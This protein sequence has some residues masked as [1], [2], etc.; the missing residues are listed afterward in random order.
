MNQ[1]RMPSPAILIAVLAL[2]AALAGTAVAGPDAST[3]AVSKK[4][5]KKIATKQINKLAPGLSVASAETANTANTATTATTA[6]TADTAGIASNA[7]AVNGLQVAKFQYRGDD[8]T[9]EQEILT[10]FGGLTLSAGCG[11]N[12]VDFRARNDSGENAEVVWDKV[13]DGAAPQG[14]A[15]TLAP[16]GSNT[17]IGATLDDGATGNLTFKTAS[18]RVVTV[19]FSFDENASFPRCSVTG[20][21][22][23]G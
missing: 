14:E 5:V 13:Q 15:G 10:N 11:A 7:N 4:T 17:G 9:G 18:N 22:M 6:N 23:G 12:D 2:V 8:T 3:S 21:A 20:I 1:M 16:G 19:V